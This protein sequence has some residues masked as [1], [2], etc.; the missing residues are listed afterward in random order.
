MPTHSLIIRLL[1]AFA[2]GA[3]TVLSFAP[4]E[5]YLFAVV[6]PAI[7][8]LIWLGS[9]ARMAFRTGW[10]FGLGLF[11]I[12]VFW[13]HISID[14]FG[15]VGT[16]LAIFITLAFIA[17]MAL[18]YGLLGWLG[19]RIAGSGSRVLQ[20]LV[21]LLL[22]VLLEWLRG[23]VLTGFPWLALGYSQTG[24]PLQGYAPLLGVYGVSL[25][26][27]LSAASLVAVINSFRALLPA[28]LVLVLVWGGGWFLI[29]KDWTIPSGDALKVSI[30]QANVEQSL[31]WKPE[32]KQPTIDLYLKLTR[33][34]WGSDLIVWPET[35]IPAFYHQLEEDLF[36]GL[37][38]EAQKNASDLLFGIA[39]WE[40]ADRR[41]YNS[42]STLGSVRNAY[43]KRHLVP[44][45]EFMP[46]RLLLQPLIEYLQIPMSNF[47][48]GE[49]ERPLIR[50][51][52]HKAGV[53]ICYE[54]A[55][56]E[57]VIQAMPDAEFLV[58]ASNDAW[59]GDS[60][61]LPQHL[62]IAR[63]R[64][65]ETGRYQLRATNTGISAFIGSKG[66]LLGISPIFKQYVLRGEIIPMKGMT[67]YAMVG[68]WG[69]VI[70]VCLPLVLV[71]LMRRRSADTF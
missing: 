48:A 46:M 1:T 50:V 65:I 44:F 36:Q 18:Y 54:D 66:E 70:L 21:Y 58:N 9:D 55:F 56:G 7:L 23:W 27:M 49:S 40:D 41:Y 25:L 39:V 31:K 45:G 47:A 30:I 17:G 62:Q 59:F 28:L 60:L 71:M 26:V 12:G 38:L 15:N 22:W 69:V 16:G 68:N 8:L 32:T 19:Q 42:M 14:Q 67:P 34:E 29:Q 3:V 5:L 37:E 13:M 4:F 35:A 6:G 43:Y 52:G 61:A 20:L 24:T 51:A 64:S 63:M 53:S 10:A 2:A 33:Q 11:G 57:E